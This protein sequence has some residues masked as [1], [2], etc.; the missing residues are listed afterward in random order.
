MR[1]KIPL[2]STNGAA[3]GGYGHAGYGTP[4]GGG[5][6]NGAG[7]YS[8]QGGGYGGGGG[9]P[10]GAGAGGYAYGSSGGGGGGGGGS[11]YSGYGSSTGGG[12]GFGVGMGEAYGESSYGGAADS[13]SSLKGKKKRPGSSSPVSLA[14]LMDKF[15]IALIVALLSLGMTMYYRSQYKLVLNKFH[16]Q[17]ISEA[18]KSYE[19]LEQEKKRFQREAI[20]GKETDRNLKN[21]IRELEKTNRE[22]RKQQDELKVRYEASGGMG[23]EESE[24]LKAREGA[25]K[26]QVQ[27]LQ[28]ATQRESKRAVMERY[29]TC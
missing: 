4:V 22:L 14:L 25:W 1:R 13:R 7:G 23:V 28:N 9:A 18:V 15:V 16:V 17:S 24:K 10:G 19:R 20:S 11:H 26:K 29:V 5:A 27:L 21:T 2:P 8:S 3:A 12:G 6:G